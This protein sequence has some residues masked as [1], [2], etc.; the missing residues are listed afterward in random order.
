MYNLFKSLFILFAFV[1]ASSLLSQTSDCGNTSNNVEPRSNCEDWD[2]YQNITVSNT[3]IK[4]IRVTIHVFQKTDGTGNFAPYNSGGNPTDDWWWLKGL[5][6]DASATFGSLPQMNMPTNSPYIT[7]SRIRFTVAQIMV[8]TN[9]NLWDKSDYRSSDTD[10]NTLYNHIITQSGVNFKHNSIHFLL[11]GETYTYQQGGATITPGGGRASGFGDKKWMMLSNVFH[12]H[13]QNP[14][15]YWPVGLVRHEFGHNLGLFHTWAGNDNCDDTPRNPC[16]LANNPQGFEQCWNLNSPSGSCC[17]QI[18]E[19]SNNVMDYN[20]SQGAL[21]QCQIER[22]H[23]HLLGNKGNVKDVVVETI[24]A[25][26]PTIS[27]PNCLPLNGGIYKVSNYQLGTEVEWSVSPSSKVV[28]AL[29]CG[30]EVTIVP[31]SGA[32]GTATITFTVYWGTLGTRTASM[33]FNIGNNIEGNITYSGGSQI[34]QT[35]NFVPAT[36]MTVNVNAPG[37]NSFTWTKTSGSG[38]FF[39]S[40]AGATLSLTLPSSGSISFNVTTNSSCGMIQRTVTFISSTGFFSIYPNPT[41]D[42][43]YIEAAEDYEVD[44]TDENGVLQQL[45]IKPSIEKLNIYDNEGNLVRKQVLNSRAKSASVNLN[46]LKSGT[47]LV[48]VISEMIVYKQTIIKI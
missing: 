42:Y 1:P 28:T 12:F 10:G 47:Y 23:W 14:S 8:W 39:T 29:G 30:N 33:T 45:Q 43:L 3:P 6:E 34:M 22:M 41:S 40:N 25:S 18:T 44:Y 26:N 19:V 48:E 13:M 4:T 46:G 20:A 7:D 36:N 32:T 9:D 24:T 35:V 31:A 27:G 17:D 21:T 2:D 15:T 11:P 5:V 16:N 38:T 37:S